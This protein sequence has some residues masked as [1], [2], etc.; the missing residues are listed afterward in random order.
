MKKT[1]PGTLQPA[2]PPQAAP[3]PTDTVAANDLS[4][5]RPQALTW[6]AESP[7]SPIA[8][9]APDTAPLA[10]QRLLNNIQ[11]KISEVP[12][13]RSRRRRRQWML[14]SGLIGMTAVSALWL[15]AF[16]PSF[17]PPA[18]PE[19]TTWRAKL[20][21]GGTL[22]WT[23]QH[24][25]PH[26]LRHSGALIRPSQLTAGASGAT[27]QTPAGV[28][29]TLQAHTRI[30]ASN[31]SATEA[32]PERA[33]EFL[34]EHGEVS[35]Q[36]P[37]LGPARSLVVRTADAWVR[38]HG[39]RFAVRLP[40][41]TNAQTCV[42]VSEG[43]VEVRRSGRTRFLGAGQAWGCP[44]SQPPAR[45]TETA[46]GKSS[47]G[48][49]DAQAAVPQLEEPQALHTKAGRRGKR[50]H[51]RRLSATLPDASQTLGASALA[52]QNQLLARGLAAERTGDVQQAQRSFRQLLS[53]YPNSPLA[54]DARLGL[55]RLPKTT[56]TP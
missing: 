16:P 8:S 37:P 7:L 48:S 38:V 10:R 21:Q 36:V 13:Q 30:R 4:S 22:Q 28:Q 44:S 14:T 29:L 49:Q 47:D 51:S 50:R 17:V 41:G 46:A 31:P 27:L 25:R 53:E 9:T 24:G 19:G 11:Q 5:Q 6:L 34:L 40:S 35:L 43:R 12:R 3:N 32:V 54:A 26:D 1:A 2:Q 15:L 56:A 52:K 18:A 20:P 39:T 45:R 33:L 55:Q 42:Q 23:D